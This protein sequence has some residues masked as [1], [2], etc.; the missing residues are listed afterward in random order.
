MKVSPVT[1][2][3]SAV[4]SFAEG[5]HPALLLRE[6]H[7][8]REHQRRSHHQT[9][10]QIF[11]PQ[12][13]ETT[14]SPMTCW[15]PP[16][17]PA[18][19]YQLFCQLPTLNHLS[20]CRHNVARSLSRS[21]HKP[22]RDCFSRKR[23]TDDEIR[24]GLKAELG[25]SKR[26]HLFEPISEDTG[27]SSS[28]F[29]RLPTD[30]GQLRFSSISFRPPPVPGVIIDTGSMRLVSSS[31]SAQPFE[32]KID[33]CHEA[34]CRRSVASCLP[35]CAR[36]KDGIES[37]LEPAA[38]RVHPA[39]SQGYEGT[40]NLLESSSHLFASRRLVVQEKRSVQRT[41]TESESANL[42]DNESFRLS[43]SRRS[44]W[45]KLGFNRSI[46]RAVAVRLGTARAK[47]PS[48]LPSAGG[49]TFFDSSLAALQALGTG[50]G[51]LVRY[52]R[53]ASIA[54]FE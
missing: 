40:L 39:H 4:P 27:L 50:I 31:K 14:P 52:N 10:P 16:D 53:M 33:R 26:P 42:A 23:N 44:L 48:A 12:L 54:D 9:V 46:S 36:K 25:T 41:R 24:L 34:N 17:Q 3:G 11:S 18:S 29:N 21:E 45:I 5:R 49:Q 8:G 19:R 2:S 47:R 28:I 15:K 1:L 35:L 7:R 22:R 13:Q 32:A 43:E 6:Q 38:D 37:R 51:E 20:R 30:D